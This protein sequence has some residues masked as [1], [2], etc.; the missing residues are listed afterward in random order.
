MKINWPFRLYAKIRWKLNV[1]KLYSYRFQSIGSS[2]Y[3]DKGLQVI[4]DKY[5]TIGNHFYAERNLSLQAW[6]QYRGQQFHPK[7]HIGN[8]VSMMS[9]CQIS[10]V[11]NISISDGVL[12][13]N[14]VFITDN[15]HGNINKDQIGLPPAEK[16]LYSKGSVF[17][18]EN[19]WIGRN[20]CIMPG[21]KI[22]KGAIIGANAVVT[23]DIPDYC[24]AAG[25]PARVIKNRI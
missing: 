18:G 13:G 15:Y 10:A 21:V 3:A 8:H 20:V 4:G 19:V 22:G 24:V 9:D 5:I 14:N 2:A 7:I 11:D 25:V 12:L 6:D 1:R 23:K 16:K 17:I